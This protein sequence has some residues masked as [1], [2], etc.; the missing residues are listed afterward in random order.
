MGSEL[1]RPRDRATDVVRGGAGNV[2]V[3][4]GQPATLVVLT[5]H[6]SVYL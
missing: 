1:I 4:V 6:E 5:Q 3:L 2:R